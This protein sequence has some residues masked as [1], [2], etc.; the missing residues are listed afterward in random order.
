MKT[1]G[2]IGDSYSTYKGFVPEDYASWYADGGNE[3][4][5]DLAGVE[6]TWWKRFEKESG[7]ELVTNCSFSGSAVSYS[8]YPEMDRVKTSFIYRMKRELGENSPKSDLILIFSGTN[9]FWAGAPVGRTK[10]G[11]WNADDFKSF[12]P[13]FCYM[14]SYLQKYNPES[15]FINLIND[16]ITSEIREI[17]LEAC[18]HF[19]VECLMLKS[20]EKQNG[21]PNTAGMRSIAEQ[22]T[23]TYGLMME[24]IDRGIKN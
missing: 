3:C 18:D 4:E 22:L 15:K 20:I 19:D 1:F 16:E 14:L 9:D 17:Q 6:N 10:Y 8:G 7:L 24:K 2:I 12:G 23:M 21:H 5:N 11:F 13:S